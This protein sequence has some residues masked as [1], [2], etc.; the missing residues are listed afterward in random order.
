MNLD[1]AQALIALGAFFLT[2]AAAILSGMKWMLDR[3]EWRT[4][5][6]FA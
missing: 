4:E 2:F 1:A 3:V 6:N 5:Q